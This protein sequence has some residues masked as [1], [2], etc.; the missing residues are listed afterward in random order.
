MAAKTG[1][2]ISLKDMGTALQSAVTAKLL[3]A[4]PEL[5]KLEGFIYR[6]LGNWRPTTD[7]AQDEATARPAPAALIDIH[8]NK[9]AMLA[10]HKLPLF[11]R[12]NHQLVDCVALA[13]YGSVA[14]PR[15]D[16][17]DILSISGRCM[18]AGYGA[19]HRSRCLFR[20][21]GA[22]RR[23]PGQLEISVPAAVTSTTSL[24]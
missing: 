24:R 12:Q 6:L 7:S 17:Y 5:A 3:V 9:V 16:T 19:L 11:A 2:D 22:A 4:Q 13:T 21:H 23:S 20:R 10:M 15:S 18:R 8:R 1:I 14:R